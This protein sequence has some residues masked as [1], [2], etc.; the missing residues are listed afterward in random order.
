[1]L[2]G[3]KMVD[4]FGF[5]CA[6]G[7]KDDSKAADM[8]SKDSVQRILTAAGAEPSDKDAYWQGKYM[9]R[10]VRYVRKDCESF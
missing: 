8:K 10:F 9:E 5:S 7:F 6:S 4:V 1:M 2:I 3:Q